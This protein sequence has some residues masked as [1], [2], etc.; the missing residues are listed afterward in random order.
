[1]KKILQ[2]IIR[3]AVFWPA[4]IVLAIPVLIIVGTILS[5]NNFLEEEEE[6]E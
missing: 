3:Y 5:V 2:H 1:V 4:V 6:E